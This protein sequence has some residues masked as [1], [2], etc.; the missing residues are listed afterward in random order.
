MDAKMLLASLAV[1]SI[2]CVAAGAAAAMPLPV[3]ITLH[4]GGFNF[5]NIGFRART[6]HLTVV[7]DGTRPH[8]LA[9]RPRGS[10]G[11]GIIER[12]PALAPGQSARLSLSLP[13][14]RYRLFSPFDHDRRHGLTVPMAVVAPT[15]K[16]GQ[17][18]DRVFYDYGPRVL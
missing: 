7:N 16:G 3:T 18:M 11:A 5:R 13:P 12:T 17:E 15:A 4:D 2:G 8:A 9:I 10:A 1:A 6:V 14:G